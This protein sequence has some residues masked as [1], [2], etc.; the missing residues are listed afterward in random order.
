M[1]LYIGF[2]GPPTH[3][4]T[5]FVMLVFGLLAFNIRDIRH[6]RRA[7]VVDFL[8]FF[9]VL[10][11]YDLLRGYADHALFG[12]HYLPQLR[13]DE[14]LFGGTAPTVRLQHWLWHA[15]HVHFWDYAVWVIYLTHFVVMPTVAAVLWK[16]DYR[17]FRPFIALYLGLTL[18]GFATYVLYPAAPPWLASQAGYLQPTTRIV[19]EMWTTVGVHSAAGMF[20]GGNRY[21][22]DVAAVPSL[23]GAYPMLLCLF[24]WGSTR[25]RWVRALLA[26]YVL[27]MAF[28]LVYG[29]EHYVADILLGWL[30]AAVTF[31]VGSRLIARWGAEGRAQGTSSSR[32][33]PRETTP[34]G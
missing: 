15:G 17:R 24:F 11:L 34:V 10:F 12:T 1:A 6:W 20:E 2:Q 16:R 28:T 22:N 18:A 5:V 14:I 25:R 31:V 30:Y 8:P 29:A 13:V 33:A 3:T 23:H 27:A 7:V 21:A 4:D 26:T 19:R 32:S 9:V